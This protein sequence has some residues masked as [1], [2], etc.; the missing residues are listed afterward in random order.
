MKIKFLMLLIISSVFICGCEKNTEEQAAP[1]NDAT[2][3]NTENTSSSKAPDFT[4]KDING[5]DVKLS[6]YKGK[7]VILDFWATWCP[8][9][10]KGIPDLISLQNEYKNDLVVIG[11][12]LDQKNTINEVVPFSK[13]YGINYPV[14][15]GDASVV[16][17]YGGIEA[18]PTS[19]IID[20]EGNIANKYVGLIPKEEYVKY[21][22]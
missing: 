18:I 17:R 14:V 9:C 3:L 6:D 13:N 2:E 10:R 8:P 11:I 12:S 5:K 15:Y 7:V 22:Q 19:F 21:L 16:Q 4:L 20:R 1:E